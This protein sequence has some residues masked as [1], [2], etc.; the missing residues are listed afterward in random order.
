VRAP[1]RVRDSA[2]PATPIRMC[3]TLCIGLIM[4][5]SSVSS[6]SIVIPLALP[7]KSPKPV[8]KKP[9]MPISV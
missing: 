9:M 4:N 8:M 1:D 6:C 5:P 2:I 3:T 7:K